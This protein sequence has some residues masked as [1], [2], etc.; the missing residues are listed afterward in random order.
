MFSGIASSGFTVGAGAG[1]GWLFA[2]W[3]TRAL[4]AWSQFDVSI[5]PDRTVLLFT[6]GV[7]VLAAL[8]FGLAPLRNALRVSPETW[9]AFEAGDEGIEFLAFGAG[10]SGDAEMDEDF[11]PADAAS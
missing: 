5:T 6:L 4:A 11:W 9:R 2:Q 8:A 1:L 3:S 10:E 7:S